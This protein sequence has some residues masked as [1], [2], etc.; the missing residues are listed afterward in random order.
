MG[1]S[2]GAAWLPGPGLQG[3]GRFSILEAMDC[4]LLTRS[5]VLERDLLWLL[6]DT[7]VSPVWLNGR[8]RRSSVGGRD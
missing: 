1:G 2:T 3:G 4:D 8:L 6:G 5:L 7:S